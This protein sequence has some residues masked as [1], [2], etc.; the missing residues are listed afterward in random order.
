MPWDLDELAAVAAETA[1]AAGDVLLAHAGDRVAWDAKSTPTDP[2]T[3]ADRAS[4]RA[5]VEHLLARRPDDG[6]VGEEA[7]GNR[8]GT[9]GL[10]WVVDPLDGTVNFTLGIRRW[11]VSIAAVDD[12][13]GVVG[14]VLDPLVP[15]L[16]R[17]VRGRGTTRN[18]V[19]VTVSDVTDPA[20]AMVATGFFYDRDVRRVQGREVADLV[21][22]IRDVRR[23]GA[24][25]LDL[26]DVACGR[27]D[28][29]AEFGL[30]HWDWAAGALLVTE[31]GGRCSS[32]DREIQGWTRPVTVAAG[33]GL[34]DWLEDWARS[35]DRPVAD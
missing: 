33:R 7:T 18:D 17:A 5:V 12:H 2:V 20:F 10:R 11:A 6:I 1:Q 19:P 27:V 16:F 8:R 35:Q 21:T 34:H 15:E 30:N 25:S 13:G 28:G 24:A 31:A 22:R 14:V 32:F 3:A 29:F 23:G 4:E 26:A 9:S